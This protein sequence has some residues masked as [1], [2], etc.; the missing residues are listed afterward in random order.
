MFIG[1]LAITAAILLSIV[2]AIFSISGLITI[3][4]GAM[5]GAGVMGGVLEFSKI[6]ATVWLY[7]FWKKANTLL[8]SYFIIAI[9]ILIAISS[10]GIFGFLSKAYVGQGEETSN[11]ET[12]LERLD[13]YIEREERSIEQA[14]K[15]LDTLDEAV[16]RYLDLDIITRGIEAREEQRE[17]R[18]KLNNNVQEAEDKISKYEDE[19]FELK[20]QLNTLE[21]EVG[22]I[23]HI[24]SLL[25]GEEDSENYYDTAARILII[26]IVIVFDPF[27]VLLMVAGNIALD[28][29]P[30]SKRG[31]PKGS[32][33]KKSNIDKP[34]SKSEIPQNENNQETNNEIN[35]EYNTSPTN[36]NKEDIPKLH[37]NSP[38]I[39]KSRR[40]IS[41]GRQKNRTN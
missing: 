21:V 25:Y 30:Q 17:D 3:F 12:R 38:S 32:K 39:K 33:N 36:T 26:L 5:I 22:P 10:I 19:A 27:A 15:Q 7:S 20:Q 35:T 37:K 16:D 13:G 31:R 40:V 18:E 34:S 28:K 23:K 14:Q 9:V 11:I 6:S 1:I 24:A 41:S 8:K 29:K 2:S 4:S